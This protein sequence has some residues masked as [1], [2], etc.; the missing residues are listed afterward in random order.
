MFY[1]NNIKLKTNYLF[2]YQILFFFEVVKKLY[3]K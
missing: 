1:Q 2:I 3:E